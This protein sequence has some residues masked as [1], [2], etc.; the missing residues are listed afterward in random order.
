MLYK[1]IALDSHGKKTNGE[2]ETTSLVELKKLLRQEKLILVKASKKSKLSKKGGM[3]QRVKAKDIAV[4]TR[5]LSTMINA[6]VGLIRCFEILESQI[7]NPKLKEVVSQIKEE[8]SSGM[9]L[10]ACLSKHPKY[11]DKL[12]I[13]MVKA[14]EASGML[15]VVLM[16]IATSLEKAEEI[17]GKVKG[18]MIYP[19]VVFFTA[20]VVMFFM[21]AFIIPKFMLL[22]EGTGVEMPLLTRMVMRASEI[23]SKYWYLFFAGVVGI[24]YGMKKIIGKPKGKRYFDIILL[25]MPLLGPFVRKTAMA[26][27]TRTMSTLLNSGVTIL[28]SFD[29]AAEIVGNTLIAEAILGAKDSIR[30]GASIYK[31]LADSGQFP[32]MVTDMIEVGEESGQ[33]SEILEKVADFTEME[34]EE[35]VRNLLA[36]FEPLIILF[37]AVG[38]G[39][40]IIAMFLPLFK[41]SDVVG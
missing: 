28:M 8:I 33:L 24:F 14:G 35:A 15:D 5:G 13:S 25:K 39:I 16:K 11:C 29:I 3:F 10:A 20:M 27:F 38:V 34:L 1:Y 17:K 40:L 9:P 32:A 19:S 36:A 31:P 2:M 26:R 12:Y 4:F 21:L 18:A 6:G 23:A 22:F 37:M 7:Q 30:D 41:M